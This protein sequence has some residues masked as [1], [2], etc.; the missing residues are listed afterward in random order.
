MESFNNVEDD[1]MTALERYYQPFQFEEGRENS[2]FQ[3]VEIIEVTNSNMDLNITKKVLS[4]NGYTKKFN[5][6]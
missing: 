3:I 6:Q 5:D 1:S 2:E 4:Q